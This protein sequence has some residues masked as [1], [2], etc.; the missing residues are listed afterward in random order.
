MLKK[1]LNLRMKN[2]SKIPYDYIILDTSPGI[3]YWSINTLAIS[4]IIILSLKMDNIDI[5]GTKQMASDVYKSF[6]EYGAKSYLLLNKTAGYCSPL[7]LN[8]EV[9]NKSSKFEFIVLEQSETITE[10]EKYLNMDVISSLPCYCDIQ[11]ARQ[12]FL[13]VLKSP[14]HPFTNKINELV[15]KLVAS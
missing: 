1:M 7:T 5:E 8:K 15:E 2:S 3:R 4:D 10:L 14:D 13:T 6:I 12:E 11:F 9:I